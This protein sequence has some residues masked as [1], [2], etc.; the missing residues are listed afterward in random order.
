MFASKVE[1]TV[2]AGLV[3]LDFLDEGESNASAQQQAVKDIISIVAKDTPTDGIRRLV[4]MMINVY[5]C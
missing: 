3:S 5:S 2:T 1:R 4:Q